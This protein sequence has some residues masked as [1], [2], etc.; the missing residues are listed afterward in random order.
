[1]FDSQVDSPTFIV[2]NEP[3]LTK[4]STII[5]PFTPDTPAESYPP[6]APSESPDVHKCQEF[7][8]KTCGCHFVNGRPC[9][10]LFPLEHYI[11]LR[12][13]SSFLIQDELDF[14]LIGAI[15]STVISRMITSG[16]AAI[17]GESKQEHHTC[18]TVM[19]YAKKHVHSY[20]A[21]VSINYEMSEIVTLL[22]AWRHEC[23]V[24]PKGC[25]TIT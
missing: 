6:D 25:L 16:M 23:M 4:T 22:M 1:M 11:Q 21:L 3:P 8:D 13:Q 19:R 7:V 2:E 24:T 18:I 10:D 5:P 12:A 15:M 9:S 20:M 14:T 17:K